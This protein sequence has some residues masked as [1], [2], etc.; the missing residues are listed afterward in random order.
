MGRNAGSA[1]DSMVD[2]QVMRS[3]AGPS[4]E[5]TQHATGRFSSTVLL[6][7]SKGQ[8]IHGVYKKS[9][10]GLTTAAIRC[11]L[12]FNR[13]AMR[14]LVARGAGISSSTILT[15]LRRHCTTPP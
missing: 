15:R 11:S 9:G 3:P 7:S 12:V 1:D 13:A 14:G 5:E 8:L 4:Q 10:E 2:L 6:C